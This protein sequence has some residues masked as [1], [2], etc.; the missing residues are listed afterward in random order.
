MRIRLLTTA[1][2]LLL[3]ATLVVGAVPAVRWTIFPPP[4]DRLIPELPFT[5]VHVDWT[6][7]LHVWGKGIGDIDGDG[8]VDLIAGGWEAGGLAWYENPS[9]RRR[10]IAEGQEYSTDIETCDV[11]RD[12]DVDVISVRGKAITWYENPRWTP[13]DIAAVMVHD[14]EVV[15]LDGDGDCD[16]AGRGQTEFNDNGH[17]VLLYEQVTPTEWRASSIPVPNGEGLRAADLDGDGD[18]DIVINQSWLENTGR[19]E[20]PRHTITTAWIHDDAYVDVGDIDGDGDLDVVHSPSEL[21][22]E[23]YRVSWFEAPPNPCDSGWEE[24]VV[25]GDV[26]AVL[27]SLNV[28]DFDGDGDA[29][30][31]TAEMTQ[32]ADPDEV[33]IH[34]NTNGRGTRWSSRLIGLGGSHGMRAVDIDAD[35]DLDL[36]GGNWNGAGV[37]L[38]RNELSPR[39]RA[40]RASPPHP[41]GAAPRTG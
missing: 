19:G 32:G 15:D 4:E 20:W 28:A 17:L 7:P 10:Q 25:V 9:W 27:H 11:D 21:K 14:I 26:E 24:H 29:D 22:G 33:R 18:P 36:F 40:E 13:H 31:A 12:G 1:A 30:I 41:N 23:R 3:G 2:A 37:H 16:V 39:V 6:E 38:Y 5:K 8:D 35:G 34:L